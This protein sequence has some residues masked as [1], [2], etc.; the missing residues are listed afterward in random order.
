MPSAPKQADLYEA[1]ILGLVKEDEEGKAWIT[2]FGR[3]YR[4]IPVPAPAG[5]GKE[6]EKEKGRAN[7]QDYFGASFID[8]AEILAN[9]LEGRTGR[10]AEVVAHVR[11]PM[12]YLDVVLGGGRVAVEVASIRLTGTGAGE[13]EGE[14]EGASAGAAAGTCTGTSTNTGI[15]TA[16]TATGADAGSGAAATERAEGAVAKGG[17]PPPEETAQVQAKAQVK[18][19]AET[20]KDMKPDKDVE[21]LLLVRI[22]QSMMVYDQYL[23]KNVEKLEKR[24]REEEERRSSV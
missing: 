23:K 7:P 14:E 6:K 9:E 10:H 19:Q 2:L 1:G 12:A 11:P 5:Y 13:E 18:A 15:S 22:A 3:R 8:E 4:V 17:I 20:Q 16:S 24:L 21:D